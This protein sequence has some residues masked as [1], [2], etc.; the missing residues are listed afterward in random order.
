MV[1][2]FFKFMREIRSY[3]V[4]HQRE[5]HIIGKSNG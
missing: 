2:G 4:V 5:A 1:F 3:K